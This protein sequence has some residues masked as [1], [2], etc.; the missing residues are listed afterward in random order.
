MSR[1]GAIISL[2]FNSD[3]YTSIGKNYR[4]PDSGHPTYHAEIKALLNLP[5]HITKGCVMYV[6]RCSKDGSEDR[7]S[8]PCS[9]CHA[10]MLERGINKV[11]YTMNDEIIGSYKFRGSNV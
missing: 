7:I 9:M 8:K 5:R 11:Y 4:T 2:G 10:V 3:K 1:G 6:A